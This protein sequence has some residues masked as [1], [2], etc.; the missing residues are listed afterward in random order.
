MK[1]NY[2][3]FKLS[4]SIKYE[5]PFQTIKKSRK[6]KKLDTLAKVYGGLQDGIS[7]FFANEDFNDLTISVNGNNLKIQKFLFLTVAS[8]YEIRALELKAFEQIRILFPD[9]ILGE[10]LADIKKLIAA[11]TV[12]ELLACGDK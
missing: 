12:I 5:I 11:K 10:E 7:N 8:K 3:Y 4:N 2:Y 6:S 9:K 1:I